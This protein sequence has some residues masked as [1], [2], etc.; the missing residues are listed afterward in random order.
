[1]KKIILF[2]LLLISATAK[3]QTSVEWT[4][5][6]H[7]SLL[8]FSSDR[9]TMGGL[10]IGA[11]VRFVHG[12]N[13]VAQTDASILWANGN[14]VATRLGI[15]YQRD[16]R[17]T[18]AIFSTFN[19][20]WGQRTEVLSETGQLPPS[21][22]WVVGLR[23]APLRFEGTHGYV[24]ALEFGYGIGPDRGKSLELTILSAGVRW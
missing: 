1:M 6:L 10:G 14:A 7:Q 22:I 15:G 11:G 13:L 21:P 5:V 19:I 17:W 24:S 9:V 3:A 8:Y 12:N 16:G 20:L 2:T 23:G 18:P 4:P